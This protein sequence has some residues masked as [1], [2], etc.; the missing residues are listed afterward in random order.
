MKDGEGRQGKE[1]VQS[2]GWEGKAGEGRS[3]K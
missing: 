2:E 3:A 1:R